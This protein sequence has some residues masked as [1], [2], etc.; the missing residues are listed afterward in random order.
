MTGKSEK[1]YRLVNGD[2]FWK[3]PRIKHVEKIADHLQAKMIM[4]SR[5]VLVAAIK[6]DLKMVGHLL[7]PTQRILAA[8]KKI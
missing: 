5:V 8:K 7:H 2:R 6:E 4:I 1:S 3:E